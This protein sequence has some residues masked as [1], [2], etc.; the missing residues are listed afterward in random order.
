L[1]DRLAQV[2]MPAK[3]KLTR[4]AK[5]PD[6][7]AGVHLKAPLNNRC[8]GCGPANAEGLRLKFVFNEEEGSFVC[9]FKLSSRF[10]GPPGYAHGGIIA[11]ILDEAMGKAN[12]IRQ[13]IALTREMTVE[14][15]KPVPLGKQ[16]MAEGWARSVHGRAHFNFAEIR[17]REGTVL[18][19]SR[20]TFI[21]ID[22]HKMFAKSSKGQ[23]AGM[24]LTKQVEQ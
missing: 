12:R 1:Y 13:V 2:A 6:P 17:D 9:R 21:A 18:A 15:L 4:K 20:G 3:Q 8:F 22:P 23:T 24:E 10:G 7:A 14:Y 19:R 11:T 5:A 16:L